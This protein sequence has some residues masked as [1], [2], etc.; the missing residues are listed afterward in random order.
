MPFLARHKLVVSELRHQI[1]VLTFPN[2]VTR[3][4]ICTALLAVTYSTFAYKTKIA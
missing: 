1:Y 4:Y 2:I 3:Y